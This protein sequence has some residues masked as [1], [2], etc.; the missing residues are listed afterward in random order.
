MKARREAQATRERERR[1]NR[2]PEP[3]QR[4]RPTRRVLLET[5][6]KSAA[7]RYLPPRVFILLRNAK[8]ALG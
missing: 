4:Q 7:M 5:R 6:L 8:R 3:I 1:G 2:L